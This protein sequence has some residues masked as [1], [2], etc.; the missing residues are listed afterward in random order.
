M[1]RLWRLCVEFVQQFDQIRCKPARNVRRH[2]PH[3]KW[4]HGCMVRSR[5]RSQDNPASQ[6]IDPQHLDAT[7]RPQRR[8]LFNVFGFHVSVALRSVVV[9]IC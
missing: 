2:S 4:Q 8:A 1:R 9:P 6:L 7:D 3:A 5:P